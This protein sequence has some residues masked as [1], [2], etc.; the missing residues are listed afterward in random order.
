MKGMKKILMLGAVLS[1]SVLMCLQ[2]GAISSTLQ[3]TS[4]TPS[5]TVTYGA[6]TCI[7]TDNDR[8][9]DVHPRL[10]LGSGGIM[11][12]TYEKHTGIFSSTIPV[13]VSE[14]GG[15]TWLTVFEFDSLEFTEGTGY[16]QY[17]DILYNSFEN[18]FCLSMLDPFAEL[19]NNELSFIDGDI[20]NAQEASWYG[21]SGSGSSDYFYC[22]VA[23]TNNFY[24]ALTT[25]DG[26][27]I[28]NTFGLLYFTYPDFESPA[29][30]GGYYYDGQSEHLSAPA[31]ELEMESGARI[32]ITCETRLEAGSQITI[33]STVSDEDIL[34]SGEQQNG[35]D[36]WSD[37]EQYPGEYVA[38]GTDPDISSSGNN[39]VLVYVDG[40][41]VKCAYSAFSSTEY[42][43]GYSW[44]F[45]TVESGASA[46][47]VF[48]SGNTVQCAYAKGGNVYK[49][50]STD[51]GATW[52]AAEKINSVDGYVLAEAGSIDITDIGVV[53]T[54]TRSGTKDIYTAG[55]ADV[56]IIEV[57]SI[58]GGFG[59]SAVV[60]NTGT[61][62]A[63]DV[64][65]KISF[66]GGVFIGKEKTMTVDVAAGGQATIKTGF[67][68]GLGGTDITVQ[69][70]DASKAASGTVL[71]P[72]VIGL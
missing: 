40:G 20:L 5:E 22:S 65:C 6:D 24:F 2:A 15:E 16:L 46:P 58:S 66:D 55:A 38:A 60:K 28:D 33:K 42:D 68:F 34:T 12:C 13:A 61:A 54:D 32:F 31:Y 25:E 26:Y 23:N 17:P 64:P 69:A 57:A 10:C 3:R 21:I 47:S 7:S 14:D 39:V 59:V 37:I 9:D 51:K 4:V 56:A 70:G 27:G 1:I 19:Y 41:N 45:S 67:I 36:K 49:K 11:V 71:G 43:P 44:Q 53:W 63:T 35:M 30:M 8:D 18:L 48:M 52:G 62:D 50:V 72:I 29:G